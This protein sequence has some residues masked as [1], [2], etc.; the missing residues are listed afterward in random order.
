MKRYN[1]DISAEQIHRVFPFHVIVDEGGKILSLGKSN[2]KMGIEG[3]GEDF[4]SIFTVQRP[5]I[6]S[7][8][9]ETLKALVGNLIYLKLKDR[10]AIILRGEVEYFIDENVLVFIGSPW[11]S[12]IDDLKKNN[13]TI[14]DFAKHDPLLD[15][16]HIMKSQ[17]I[18]TQEIKE[19][20]FSVTDQKRKTDQSNKQLL[21]LQSFLDSSTDAIQVSTIDGTL[22]YINDEA[23]QR[24]GI[25][26]EEVQNYNVRDFEKVFENREAW[27]EHIDDLRSKDKIIIEGVNKNQS[28]EETFPV[29]VTV[30]LTKI[31]NNEYVIAS[32]RDISSRK[33]MESQL[34]EQEK[35]YKN[36]IANMNLGLIEVDLEQNILYANQSF[37]DISGFE[38]N[39]LIGEKATEV[40]R[41]ESGAEILEA[42]SAL[43]KRDISDNYELQILDKSGTKRWWFISGAPNYNEQGELIGSIGI[44]LDITNQKK[45]EEELAV[46]KNKAEEASQAKEAFLANMSH[47]IRTPLN[48]IIGMIR[49]LKREDLSKK[50]Q[51]YLNHTDTASKHLLSIVNSILDISKIEAGEFILEQHHF[52]LEALVGNIQSIL[53]NKAKQKGLSFKTN[54][55][56]AVFPAHL[57][58][59][60]RLRQVL[61]NLLDN[62]IKF[63]DK[64]YVD[65]SLK[66]L[67]TT[68][69][70]QK[71]ILVFTDT[72][73]GMDQTYLEKVFSKFSQEE[74]ST[75]RKFGGT[76][77]GMFIT[78]EIVQLMNG[79][80]NVSSEKSKGTK[81]T[82]ELTLPK[83][84]PKK[85]I[86]SDSQSYKDGL[87]GIKVL[88]V[89][90][91]AMNRF[92][93]IKSLSYFGCEVEEAEN[94]LLALES[95]KN[96]SFDV[97]LMDIQM[98][99]LDGVETT[100]I[101]RKDFDQ[102]VP[103]IAV[104]ANAFRKD[105]DLYLSIG[106]NDY[107]TKPFNEGELF[108]AIQNHLNIIPDSQSNN[109]SSET[110]SLY[111]LDKL[112]E[113]SSG[114]K[115]F[116]QN[117]IEIFIDSA[118]TTLSEIEKALS[119]RNYLK[120]SQVAHKIKP[121]LEYL[122]MNDIYFQAKEIELIAK[123]EKIQHSQIDEKVNSFIKDLSAVVIQLQKDF[124]G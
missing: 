5:V 121:N 117:M 59:S 46:A 38:I 110:T 1:L 91:N 8:S 26:K 9:F 107:V 94:G 86:E 54:I 78:R 93:A 79:R 33:A 48:A 82:I 19:L 32:S 109:N 42:K 90:D 6:E 99:E 16:L 12:T 3:V 61:I 11:F 41:V 122:G 15:L 21:M 108:F 81:I 30:K 18:T 62:A 67:E 7:Y 17:E 34:V 69:E 102:Q 55:D 123:A 74:L 13:L 37:A 68:P 20:L 47:E 63:T 71:I 113:V 76:G 77:L 89:E 22:T 119:E 115:A 60:A 53:F 104:S 112:I 111:N 57:G 2:L 88:L 106:M 29:E 64:G 92:I 44:H 75:S 98:P 50:Q 58:D 25:K 39:E 51:A 118:P 31:G 103:I 116:V 23:S 43:R 10:P 84:N 49:E 96:S 66:V 72:G 101:I 4:E 24:L 120:I 40:V 85:L 35:K 45:L 27:Q 56:S 100:K 14:H 70:S 52:S 73:I 87:K 95:L 65:L 83:G 97:I 105:I 80:I 124:L 28:T 114:D 36:I